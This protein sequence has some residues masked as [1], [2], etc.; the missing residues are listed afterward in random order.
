MNT[1]NNFAR[2]SIIGLGY[3]GLP[4]AATIATRGVSVIGVDISQTA[5]DTINCGSAHIDETDLDIVLNAAVISGY[6]K[7]VI[8][9]QPADVFVI[10]V[11]TPVNPNKPPTCGLLKLHSVPLPRFWS[12]AIS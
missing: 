3:V 4:T 10:A 8:E 6:L 5:V 1:I 12:R 7:A 9:P 2:V 11:P